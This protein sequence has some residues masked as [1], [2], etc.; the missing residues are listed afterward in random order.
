VRVD[1]TIGSG[2]V[3]ITLA[4]PEWKEAGVAPGKFEI[5]LVDE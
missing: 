1:Q 3:K 2:K 4:F 5:P